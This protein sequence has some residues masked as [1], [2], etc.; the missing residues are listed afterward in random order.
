MNLDA[1]VRRM[2]LLSV[3][4]AIVLVVGLAQSFGGAV[5]GGVTWDEP[6]HVE[7][8]TNLFEHGWYLPDFQLVDGEPAANPFVYGPAFSVTSHAVNAV[9]GAEQ[10]GEPSGSAA[11][12]AGRHVTLALLGLLAVG[13][14][15]V[16]AWTLTRSR[17]AG[18]VAAAALTTVPLWTGHTMFNVKDLPAA[19]GYTLVTAG[20]VLALAPAGHGPARRARVWLVPVAVAV[21]VFLGF[22]V[23]LAFW[24][25]LGAAFATFVG[26]WWLRR[27]GRTAPADGA[28]PTARS[29]LADGGGL[30]DLVRVVI[31][32]AVGLA[33]VAAS[34]PRALATPFTLLT[35]AITGST[36]YP[37]N[38]TT[39]TAGRALASLDLPWWYLPVWVVASIPSLLL[40]LAVGGATASVVRTLRSSPGGTSAPWDRAGAGAI[41]VLQQA[42]LLPLIAVVTGS[43][44]Y[45]GLRQHLY[46]VPALAVLVGVGVDRLIAAS[47]TDRGGRVW[48]RRATV[49]IAVIGLVV[50]TIEQTRLF[51]Y[52]YVHVDPVVGIGGLNDRWET[53][54]WK[55]SGREA[56][57][58]VPADAEV[59][60]TGMYEPARDRGPFFGPCAADVT[61]FAEEQGTDVRSDLPTD[62][63]TWVIGRKRSG[64]TI[65][66]GCRSVDEVTRPLR[67]EDVVMA[68]ILVCDR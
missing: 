19:A 57:T 49:A 40:M 66:D 33:A 51:P 55:A 5:L 27:R 56:V 68:H 65:P 4:A 26:V 9:T 6:T 20:L 22:G 2:D 35:E 64:N 13:A 10:L 48:L 44:M 31:G 54:F 7:R 34:Y 43:V 46:L 8:T 47:R 61:T 28:H 67:G 39:L 3:V 62:A 16:T 15:G 52:N 21:G 63:G 11:A 37:W 18:L 25:P 59:I 14:V 60:C 50:P 12:Y 32:G 23:R 53:D 42:T 38:G 1:A 58:R 17:R 36:A 24:A 29:P 41:L 45:D 30:G